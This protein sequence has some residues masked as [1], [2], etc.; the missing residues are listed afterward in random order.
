MKI[1]LLITLLIA[2]LF[3]LGC[4]PDFSSSGEHISTDV[5][6]DMDGDSDT[7][8]DDPSEI[9]SDTSEDTEDDGS[10]EGKEARVYAHSATVLYEINPVDLTV[11]VVGPFQFSQPGDQMTDIALDADGNMTGITYTNIY[12]V[13]KETAACHFLSSLKGSTGYNGLS[14]LEDENDNPILV[15]AENNS[16]RVYVID[17]QTGVDTQLGAYGSQLKSSGDLVY[18]KGAGAFATAMKTESATD[19]LLSVDPTD[20]SGTLIGETGFSNIWGLAYWGG[21]LYG[22]TSRGEFILIDPETGAGTLLEDTDY[23]FWGAGVTTRA[24]VVI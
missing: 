16:G 23:S 8:N 15:G 20:G 14:F 7:D 11:S 10:T 4:E 19:V 17:P 1:S 22:F 12:A 24:P 18:V 3:M 13:D 21:Q 2:A 5:D 9:D 6:S